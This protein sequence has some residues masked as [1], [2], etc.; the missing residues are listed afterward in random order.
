MGE[1]EASGLGVQ[2]ERVTPPRQSGG[3]EPRL[4]ALRSTGPIAVI[5]ALVLGLLLGGGAVA[6]V[7]ITP[8]SI[9]WNKLTPGLQERIDGHVDSPP[10][11]GPAGPQGERGPQGPAGHD[12]MDGEL[13][14]PELPEPPESAGR[15][16]LPTRANKKS[17]TNKGRR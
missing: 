2:A 12:G 3:S 17:I 16:H 15:T 10:I 9:G 5:V 6:A 13:E 11:P 1:S 14:M 8:H 4:R 7:T